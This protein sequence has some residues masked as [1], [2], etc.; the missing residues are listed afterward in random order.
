[1]VSCMLLPDGTQNMNVSYLQ[2]D[3]NKRNQLNMSVYVCGIIS[4][5]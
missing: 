4:L 2:V 5:M 3:F 1:M